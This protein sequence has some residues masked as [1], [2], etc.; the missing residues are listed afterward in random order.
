MKLSI[1][2]DAG[3]AYIRLSDQPVERTHQINESIYVDLDNLD[4]ACGIE[5]LDLAH[6][7]PLDQIGTQCHINSKIIDDLKSLRIAETSVR[8][9]QGRDK[10]ID[11][12]RPDVLT[13]I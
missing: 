8:Q 12:F 2:T 6:E 11:R 4:V 3:V 7:L 13:S 9:Y 5:L 1:D 10:T